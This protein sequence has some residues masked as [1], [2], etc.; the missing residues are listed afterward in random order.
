MTS[1]K[2]KIID[3]LLGLAARISL[4][5]ELA[6]AVAVLR[7]VVRAIDKNDPEEISVYV[8]RQL[9]GH[10]KAPEGPATEK[11]FVAM[12]K[13]GEEFIKRALALNTP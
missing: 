5:K 1:L 11:E 13:A 4:G 9:P 8:F 10:W 2:N 3:T 12:I 7:L 6:A